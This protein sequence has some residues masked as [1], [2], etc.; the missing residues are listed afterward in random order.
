M[1]ALLSGLAV[2]MFVSSLQAQSIK[3][4]SIAGSGCSAYFFCDPGTFQHNL[5]EDSSHVYTAECTNDG[6]TY[7]IICVQLKDKVTDLGSAEE[8]LIT[9]LDFI[10]KNFD[11]TSAAGYGKGHRL[12]NNENTRGVIDYWTDKDKNNIKVKGWTD[13]RYIAVLY[14]SSKNE[15]AEAKTNL[16]LDGFRLP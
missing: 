5:S 14:V 1:K 9:Y 12:N 4:Y 7:G 13:G 3:K 10:K 2:L 6:M 16:F 11:V 8:L 15:L